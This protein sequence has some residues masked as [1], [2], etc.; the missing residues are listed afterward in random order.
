VPPQGIWRSVQ[1]QNPLKQSQRRARQSLF[2]AQLAP[3]G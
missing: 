1:A 3:D 2:Q